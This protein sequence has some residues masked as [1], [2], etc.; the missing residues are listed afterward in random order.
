MKTKFLIACI[1]VVLFNISVIALVCINELSKPEISGSIII[2]EPTE[3]ED[4]E[5]K[6][7][8]I[9][10][11]DNSVTDN[12]VTNNYYIEEKNEPVKLNGDAMYNV[13]A[14][15]PQCGKNTYYEQYNETDGNVRSYVG[16]CSSCYYMCMCN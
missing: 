16:S 14:I 3:E 4:N 8:I 7:T 12:S 11:I 1:A 15:C 10:N 6:Q 9:N 13:R 5:P 2:E